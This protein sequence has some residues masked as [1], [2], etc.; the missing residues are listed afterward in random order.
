MIL[1][2]TV[3]RM[4]PLYDTKSKKFLIVW[5]MSKADFDKEGQR[6]H[7]CVGGYFERCAKGETTVF[8]V[9]NA[10]EPDKPYATV[11]FDEGRLV[12]CRIAY[13]RDAPEDVMKYMDRI[14]DHYRRAVEELQ[15]EA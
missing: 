8:F 6:Q 12:Q 3:A 2:K 9:R 5:P 10:D 14:A 15:K 4:K 11:E 7:N 13:N 1:K